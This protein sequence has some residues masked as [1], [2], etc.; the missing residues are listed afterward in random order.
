MR[1]VKLLF[2]SA[3]FINRLAL[4][5][6][7][8]L[9][10]ARDPRF[11]T[12]PRLWAEEGTIY[13]ASAIHHGVW[14]SLL[15]PHLGYYS[16]F[17]NVVTSVGLATV[18][19]TNI[20]SVTTYASWIVIL[21]TVLA[22]LWL[23]GSYWESPARK[24]LLVAFMVLGG[25]AEIWV[26]TV[27]VQFYLSA[28]TCLV[29]FSEIHLAGRAARL[30]AFV[31]LA[32]AALTGVTS[33][34]LTPLFALK[35]AM[36]S[37]SRTD[38]AVFIILALGLVVQLGAFAYLSSHTGVSRLSLSNLPNLP[39]GIWKNVT[40]VVGSG[41]VGL[42]LIALIAAIYFL[43]RSRK[44]L[45]SKLMLPALTLVYLSIVLAVLA[46]EM[47]GGGRYG[48]A[49][50][51][52]AFLILLNIRLPV[53][54]PD[55]VKSIAIGAILGLTFYH[56]FHTAWVYGPGW[57]PFVQSSWIRNSDGLVELPVFPQW[58]GNDWVIRI[59]EEQYQKFK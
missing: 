55:R 35:Y 11:F 44:Q 57:Q 54:V 34:I 49:T 13:I 14:N 17:N 7:I 4:A 42:R 6:V 10:V 24:L 27:N 47:K 5:L 33:V 9:S 39:L 51:V 18:G 32:L 40:A 30:S 29:L 16:L 8:V 2:S 38:R 1:Q 59:T 23:P 15:L 36:G 43:Y 52:I 20:A 56:F 37:R 41:P 26:N 53:A 25:S 28:F 22:P 46:L 31:V 19:L 58:K 50:S 12:A 21:I 45:T 48:Y 3:N